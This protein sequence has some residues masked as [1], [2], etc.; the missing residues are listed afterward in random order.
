[1]VHVTVS[2]TGW[3]VGISVRVYAGLVPRYGITG[4]LFLYGHAIFMHVFPSLRRYP[5]RFWVQTHILTN[6]G[7]H[8]G[9]QPPRVLACLLSC[10]MRCFAVGRSL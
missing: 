4:S 2:S 6:F 3:L 5:K 7:F 8:K 1:M 10:R 9:Y